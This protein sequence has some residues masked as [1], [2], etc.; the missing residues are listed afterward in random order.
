M[1]T[2]VISMSTMASV[3]LLGSSLMAEEATEEKSGWEGN[4]QFGYVASSGNTENS[5]INGKF[6]IK[7]DDEFW[8]HDFNAA[9]YQSTESESTTA[10][11]FKLTYQADYKINQENSYWFINASYEDDRFSGFEYRATLSTGYGNRLYDANDMTLDA[12]IGAGMRY[13]EEID[14][15]T[16]TTFTENEGMIRAAAKYLWKIEDDRS[17]SSAISVEEG[18]E[19]RISNFEIAFTTLIAGGVNMKAAYEARHVSEVPEGKEK[20]DTIVSLNILYKF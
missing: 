7:H 9:Y 13:S 19:V 6:N 8:L 11:R 4:V 15:L 20:L 5:N 12:E 10:E 16:N 3:L 1:K 17:L 14:T 2:S 18:E